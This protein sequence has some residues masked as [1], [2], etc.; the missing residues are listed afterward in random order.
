[1][2]EEKPKIREKDRQRIRMTRGSNRTDLSNRIMPKSGGDQ[3]PREIVDCWSTGQ[4]ERAPP[5]RPSIPFQIPVNPRI[6]NLAN[7]KWQRNASEGAYKP[8]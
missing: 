1:M 5:E 8:H 3:E 4:V 6:A 2:D 7:E